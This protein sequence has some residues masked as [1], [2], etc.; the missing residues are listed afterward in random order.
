MANP[1]ITD[2]WAQHTNNGILEKKKEVTIKEMTEENCSAIV[3]KQQDFQ[4]ERAL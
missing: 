2:P 1:Q 3:N 4:I